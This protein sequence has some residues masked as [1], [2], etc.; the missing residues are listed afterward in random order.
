MTLIRAG[1]FAFETV[2]SSIGSWVI[3][4]NGD[5]LGDVLIEG[6]AVGVALVEVVGVA[7]GVDAALALGET[8]GDGFGLGGRSASSTF[9][10]ATKSAVAV[11]SADCLTCLSSRA[12]LSG[13]CAIA[14][15]DWAFVSAVL[16]SLRSDP[17]LSAALRCATAFLLYVLMLAIWAEE[18]VVVRLSVAKLGTT[19]PVM[20]RNTVLT[21]TT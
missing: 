10:A 8:L 2:T 18:G 6:V 9:W 21:M 20:A 14:R 7:D 17:A 15:S 1:C 3:D 4:G 16:A 5:G 19:R 12:A 13:T 11:V